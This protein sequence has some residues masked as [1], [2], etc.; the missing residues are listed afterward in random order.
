MQQAISNP[1]ESVNDSYKKSFTFEK[2]YTQWDVLKAREISVCLTQAPA[3]RRPVQ[4]KT[5]HYRDT[6]HQRVRAP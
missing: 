4:V 2:V 6:Q 5:L 1:P 3:L